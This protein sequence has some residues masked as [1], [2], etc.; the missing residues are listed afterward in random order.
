MKKKEYESFKSKDVTFAKKAKLYIG[1]YIFIMV[2]LFL[3]MFFIQALTHFITFI[4]ILVIFD[5]LFH[6][7]FKEYIMFFVK[8]K[9][10]ARIELH[11]Q[12]PIG[13]EIIEYF[14]ENAFQNL[15]DEDYTLLQK[16]DVFLI[17]TKKLD[18]TIYDLALAV[19]FTDLKTEAVC[20]TLRELS[21][22]MNSYLISTSVVK[23]ILVVSSKFSDEDKEILQYDAQGHK[24]TVIIGLEKETKLLYY[25]YFLNGEVLDK[26]LS[27]LFKVD[28]TRKESEV[29]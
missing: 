19:Y 25:N 9:E 18:E 15:Y 29:E 14:N 4:V 8:Q 13:D 21:R 1:L 6:F 5:L 20:P 27:D 22:E 16:N 10:I 11:Q 17:A 2:V 26:V 3:A 28:V 23:V 7:V 12:F 24:N